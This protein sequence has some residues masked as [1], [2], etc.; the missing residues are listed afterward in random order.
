MNHSESIEKLLEDR[1]F[2]SKSKWLK[3]RVE[4]FDDES[5][6]GYVKSDTGELFY[7]H[8]S[9]IESKS[10]W[11]TL[12]KDKSV[13]FQVNDNPRFTQVRKLLVAGR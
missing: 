12:K 7:V 9:A 6:E 2:I 13:K 5:G 1:E 4:W 10:K 11:K 8:Y 3:G